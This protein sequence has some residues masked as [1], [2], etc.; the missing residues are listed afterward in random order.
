MNPLPAASAIKHVRASNTFPQDGAVSEGSASLAAVLTLHGD[1]VPPCV[2]VVTVFTDTK[3]IP[4]LVVEKTTMSLFSTSGQNGR[5]AE[6]WQPD[7]A[8]G[9]VSL[10][11]RVPLDSALQPDSMLPPVKT[12]LTD[13]NSIPALVV[14]KTTMAL[15]STSDQ[16]G[17]S[18]EIWQ[19]D[20]ASGYVSSTAR[21]PL[22]SALQPDSILPPVNVVQLTLTRDS[23]N[24]P[25]APPRSISIGIQC[26]SPDPL[27]VDLRIPRPQLDCVNFYGIP[28]GRGTPNHPPFGHRSEPTFI[29]PASFDNPIPAGQRG[30]ACD[31]GA[32]KFKLAIVYVQNAQVVRQ[33]RDGHSIFHALNTATGHRG[34]VLQLRQDLVGFTRMNFNMQV[35]GHSLEKWINWEC[36]CRFISALFCIH[37]VR[38]HVLMTR[39]L[40]VEE[41][42]KKMLTDG[43]WG[44][45]IE[46]FC[47][48]VSR[49][50]NVHVYKVRTRV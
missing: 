45:G 34:S 22:D 38:L 32:T 30:K 16:D 43:A 13:T 21:V 18:A 17:R 40:S 19:P 3:S 23:M 2:D 4:A 1:G 50:M 10:T 20:T 29:E 39:L 27:F 44:G 35:H 24:Q 37:C 12:V 41:Y 31:I 25:D 5:S 6:I 46:L 48:S 26:S 47:F 49:Q 14:E 9:Y 33:P 42:A 28:I 8:S 15:F 36:L 7:T 11:A